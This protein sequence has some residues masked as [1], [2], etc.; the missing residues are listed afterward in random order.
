[1]KLLFD[2]KKAEAETQ[3][4]DD[5]RKRVK[6]VEA[7]FK[8]FHES[9]EASEK[10]SRRLSSAHAVQTVR[11]KRYRR[12]GFRWQIEHGQVGEDYVLQAFPLKPPTI[13]WQDVIAGMIVVMDGIFPATIDITY[14]PP[15]MNFKVTFYTIRLAGVTKLPGWQ[16]ACEERAPRALTEIKAWPQPEKVEAATRG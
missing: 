2:G 11:Y 8:D 3:Q 1:M 14:K 9:D 16:S 12:P 10:L 7:I 15:D 5:T 13:P 6:E 4:R